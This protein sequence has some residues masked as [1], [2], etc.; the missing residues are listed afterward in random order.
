[1]INELE[2]KHRLNTWNGFTKLLTYS[3]IAVV[4][5]LSLMAITLL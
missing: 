1:M 4:V 2:Y 5:I 3:T